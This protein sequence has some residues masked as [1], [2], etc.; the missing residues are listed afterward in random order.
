VEER[1]IGL[2]NVHMRMQIKEKRRN[3]IGQVARNWEAL[4][5]LSW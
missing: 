4:I 5:K 3:V 2:K 1:D